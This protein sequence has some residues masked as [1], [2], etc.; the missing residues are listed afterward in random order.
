MAT[1][2]RNKMANDRK[3]IAL[4]L[5]EAA[6]CGGEDD[7]KHPKVGAVVVRDGEVLAMAHR[8]ELEPGEHAEFTALEKK[9]SGNLLAGATVYTTLEPCT[10][11][12]HPKVPCAQR[13]VDRKVRRV[14]IGVL[15]PN[16]RI[17]GR[18][19]WHLRESG[20]ETD[21]FSHD[22][23]L[24]VEELNRDFIRL[25]RPPLRFVPNTDEKN[26]LALASPQNG[27]KS[28]ANDLIDKLF[29]LAEK[30]DF[31]AAETTLKELQS[32]H[33]DEDARHRMQLYFWE[34]KVRHARDP[35]ARAELTKA[36]GPTGLGIL[37]TQLIA[38]LDQ[39]AGNIHAATQR[40]ELAVSTAVEPEEKARLALSAAQNYAAVNDHAQATDVLRQVASLDL[41]SR[42]R[43]QVLHGLGDAATGESRPIQKAAFFCR[44]AS[45]DPSPQN[46]F[47][48][49]YALADANL[50]A[51]S[52]AYYEL[53][54]RAAPDDTAS[55]N[56]IGVA[57]SKLGL[58]GMSI[59][60]YREAA[61]AG[62]T[63]AMANLAQQYIAAGFYREAEAE[64]KR[65][66]VADD[67]HENIGSAMVALASAKKR[68]SEQWSEERKIALGQKHFFD[69]LADALMRVPKLN[70]LTGA[71]SIGGSVATLDVLGTA[72]EAAW[73]ESS[74][75]RRF[76]GSIIGQALIGILEEW[77]Q[78]WKRWEHKG[79]MSMVMREN[80]SL[81]GIL[82]NPEGALRTIEWKR[83]VRLPDTAPQIVP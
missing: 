19:L 67:V 36:V 79:T 21:L 32:L 15:D 56:N 27:Q 75:K 58:P 63:L 6:K 41:P 26:A 46:L 24:A 17:C 77:H 68:E 59:E 50:N 70:A 80:G 29:E 28:T 61:D 52:A 1:S 72:A 65:G 40:L 48:A 13:L 45:V 64:I 25:H 30:Q 69:E 7:R 71:W 49:A 5:A 3:Y 57:F 39:H 12:N 34:L 54:L 14:V 11:R 81:S 51:M 47:Q 16:E 4:A 22:Q 9:L 23:M 78:Y 8:G 38:G 33:D 62:N 76:R 43:A 60:A 82:L 55:R 2:R 10:T 37:A 74:E 42:I 35:V 31:A 20:I 44:T 18:G 66:R 83:A 73:E 53:A